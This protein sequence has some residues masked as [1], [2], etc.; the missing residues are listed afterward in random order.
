[1]NAVKL[2]FQHEMAGGI[3]LFSAAVAALMAANLPIVSEL[4]AQLLDTPIAVKIGALKID[5]PMLLW[6]NDGLMAMF[7]L[8]VGL[9]LKREFC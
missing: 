3:L 7:F 1:M 8:L 9:E 4:Y 2:F 5:K 6:V